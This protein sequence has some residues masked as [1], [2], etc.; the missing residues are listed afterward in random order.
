MTGPPK[1][2]ILWAGKDHPTLNSGYGIVNRYILPR[3]GDRYGRDNVLIYVPVYQRDT[4]GEWEGMRVLPG[5]EWGYGEEMILDHYKEYNCNLLITLGDV[6]PLGIIPDLA[7]QDQVL[8]VAWAM[9]DWL[10]CPKNIF[11][12][13]KP[14]HK[15]VPAS[16]Y[17]ENLLRKA[18]LTNVE[19]AIWLGLNTDLWK[20][21]DR[22]RMPHLMQCLGFRYDTFN[23]LIV[24]AN[25]ERKRVRHQMEAI[26]LFRK[27]RPD[28][29]VRLYLHSFLKGDRDLLADI[30]E[31]EL[32]ICACSDQYAMLTGGFAEEKMVKMFSCA[33]LVLNVCHEGFGFAQVQAQAVGCPVIC[34]SEGAGPELVQFGIETPPAT[35]AETGS[36]QMSQ[37]LPF[38]AAVAKAIEDLYDRRMTAG[39][40]LRSEAAIKWVQENLAWD[41]I[42]EQWYGVIDRC[43]EDRMRYSMDLP[44]PS[45]GLLGR[46]KNMIELS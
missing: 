8:W 2:R 40:P 20:P 42:A 33:D 14:A 11:Y 19:K 39:K 34:L 43:M 41:K 35:V 38:P 10:G 27:T 1:P 32:D 7:A 23:I 37:A 30:D 18:G 28:A 5:R 17:G 12:R 26:R 46:A 45:P 36:H 24:A 15:L 44:E 22:D 31:L 6:T 13:I 29:R 25:Q 21:Y 16:K 9:V 3:L 4:V